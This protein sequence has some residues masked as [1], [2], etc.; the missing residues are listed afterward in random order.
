MVTVRQRLA[1][2]VVAGDV[3]GVKGLKGGLL[4]IRLAFVCVRLRG[5]GAGG[6]PQK[7]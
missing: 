2:L 3:C 1:F 5:S 7:L 4:Q 6:G